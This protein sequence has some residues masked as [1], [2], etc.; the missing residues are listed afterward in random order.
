MIDIDEIEI[1]S[2]NGGNGAVSFLHTIFTEFGGP[3]GGNGGKGGDV[4]FKTDTN[5]STL[6]NFRHKTKFFAKNGQDGSSKKRSGKNGDDLIIYVPCGTII[7]N[8]ES[9]DIMCDM[10]KP[11]MSF[12]AAKGGKGGL[13]NFCFRSSINRTPRKA[14][15][16]I[17]GEYFSV[18]LELKLLADVGLVGMPNAGKSTILSIVSNAKPKIANY[19]FTTL[20]PNLGVVQHHGKSFVIADIPGLIEGASEGI[21]LGH[22]FLKHIQRCKILAHVVDV[23]LDDSIKN[24][25]IVNQELEKFDKDL[26]KLPMIVIANK[27]DISSD[28]QISDFESF[29]VGQNIKLFKISAKKGISD[30]EDV[31]NY[32][33]NVLQ[34]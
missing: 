22:Q 31:L 29:I 32:L 18:I 25:D 8:K 34:S 19:P 1:K 21:G 16:G 13:G 11:D 3:D 5:I 30:L 9:D 10:D 2:G 17:P 4:I 27:V 33:L 20:S 7:K 24:F 15:D 14:T 23:S 26:S 12:V 28:N 6:A